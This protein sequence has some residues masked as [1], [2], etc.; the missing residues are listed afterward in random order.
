MPSKT[1]KPSGKDGNWVNPFR[2]CDEKGKPVDFRF[3]SAKSLRDVYDK[4]QRDDLTAAAGRAKILGMWNMRPPWNPEKLKSAGIKNKANFNNGELRGIIEARTGAV[5][6]MA[7][8]TTDLITLVPAA[9]ELSGPDADSI[10]RIVADEFSRTVRDAPEPIAALATM[11]QQCDLTGIGPL[12]WTDPISYKPTALLRGQLKL[13]EDSPAQASKNEIIMYEGSLPAAYVFSLFDNPDAA[14]SGGWYLE[15]LK[16]FAVETFVEGQPSYSQEGDDT[17]TSNVETAVIKLRENRVFETRQ[18]ETMKVI[19]AF[20]RETSGDRKISHYMIPAKASL[21]VFLMVRAQAYDSM[22]QCFTW[23]PYS[24]TEPSALAIRGLASMIAP[25]VEIR[26]RKHCELVDAASILTAVHLSRQQGGSPERL[27]IH[28]Q[29]VYRVLPPDVKAEQPP[30]NA[31]NAQQAI[32]MIELAS[33]SATQNA[34]GAASPQAI[35]A[36]VGDSADRRT[37]EEV[38]AL[39]E[40]NGS[41]AQ[42]LFVARM[43]VFDAI[44]REMFR[45]FMSIAVGENKMWLPEYPEI[46]DFMDRCAARMVGTDQLKKVFSKEYSVI[47]CRDIV[48]GGASVKAGQLADIISNFGGNLDEKGRIESSREYVRCRMGTVMAERLRPLSGRD[49]VPSDAASHATLENNDMLELSQVLAAPDQLH[50][51][52]IPV[53]GSLVDQIVQAV[54]NGQVTDPQRML[55]T[56]QLASEHIQAHIRYG[57]MQIGMR[58]AADAAMRSLR[59][60]RPIE[61]ELTI[62]ASNVDRVRRAEEEKRAREMQA[63]RDR[64]EGKDNEVKMHEADNKAAVELYKADRLHE[65]RMAEADSR[66]QTDMFR[67]RARQEIDRITAQSKRIREASKITGNPPPSAAGLNPGLEPVE[68]F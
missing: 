17:G 21:D 18:F 4:A 63:L 13:F 2:T 60:L 6:A 56:L 64:A 15:N 44:M 30:I 53:H 59:S 34:F 45:R 36:G 28:E 42:A 37:K 52:H 39:R 55:D 24:V 16:R 20:V 62:M 5:Y 32:Q 54:E 29:G 3:S 40:A 31:N 51:S 61:Q 43:L 11:V 50:W 10:G 41:A 48:M 68:L 23:L 7:L 67:A 46:K 14:D 35:A 19:H 27:T 49:S 38:I 66:S 65:A 58:P 26:N 57:G 22:D 25:A 12:T 9:A 8:D 33:R 1:A 47:M